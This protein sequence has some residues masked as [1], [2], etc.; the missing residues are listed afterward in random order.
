MGG[1]RG[2]AGWRRALAA[3]AA[4]LA[5]AAAAGHE[6]PCRVQV[7]GRRRGDP[8]CTRTVWALPRAE[9]RRLGLRRRTVF[10]SC[11]SRRARRRAQQQAAAS[12]AAAGL[13]NGLPGGDD[14]VLSG[15]REGAAPEGA[16]FLWSALTYDEEGEATMGVVRTAHATLLSASRPPAAAA[17]AALSGPQTGRRRKA[18]RKGARMTCV[19]SPDDLS[20]SVARAG[21]D[22]DAVPLPPLPEKPSF[23][24]ALTAASAA[25]GT[26]GETCSEEAEVLRVSVLYE[27]D[28]DFVSETFGGDLEKAKSHVQNLANLVSAQYTLQAG[29]EVEGDV[30]VDTRADPHGHRYSATTDREQLKEF[31]DRWNGNDA[32][33]KEQVSGHALVHLI[34]G[35]SFPQPSALGYAYEKTACTGLGAAVS[36]IGVLLDQPFDC[37]SSTI[38]HETGH[39]LGLSHDDDETSVMF[40]QQTT[41]TNTMTSSAREAVK[42]FVEDRLNRHELTRESRGCSCTSKGQEPNLDF[43]PI[44]GLPEAPG[45]QGG[46]QAGKCASLTRKRQ[47]KRTSGCV[48]S[49]GVGCQ[50]APPCPSIYRKRSCRRAGCAWTG[51]KRNGECS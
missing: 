13:V 23:G 2:G 35:R 37:A 3:A 10:R 5:L 9:A 11:P 19:A 24:P 34:S 32:H 4:A 31:W 41:C 18:A 39:T 30:F 28:W 16:G 33:L 15:F 17:A 38:I 20:L 26:A 1:R 40:P 21:S 51:T 29:V 49:R 7:K 6:F 22:D 27:I 50:D 47:C 36:W 43:G 12:A 46:E 25:G 45:G 8:E 42:R 48:F 14:R 44:A